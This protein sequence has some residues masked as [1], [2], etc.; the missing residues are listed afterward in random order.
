AQKGPI[1]VPTFLT[2][3]TQFQNT[4]GGFIGDPLTVYATHAVKGFFD[5][6]GTTCYFVRVSTGARA[7]RPLLDR[8]GN[9]KPTLQITAKQE[10][11]QGNNI[12]VEVLD[13]KIVPDVSA[14]RARA[15]LIAASGTLVSVSEPDEAA[16][17]RPGD[18]V[19]FQQAP[20]SERAVISSIG[21]PLSVAA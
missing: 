7:S 11:T 19:F 16:N 9:P 4:F 17:F 8:A 6:N 2:S 20:K 14:T 3:F 12:W 21:A 5:N 1:G 10:G 13:A 18:T 15:T